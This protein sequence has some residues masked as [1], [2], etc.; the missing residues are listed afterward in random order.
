MHHAL[1]SPSCPSLGVLSRVVQGLSH[2]KACYLPT[3]CEPSCRLPDV[4]AFSVQ[5][6]FSACPH[7]LPECVRID[8]S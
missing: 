2:S 1:L 3:T 8:T 7:H 5:Y 4:C 6:A